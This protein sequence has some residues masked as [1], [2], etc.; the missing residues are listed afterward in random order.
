MEISHK[1][2]SLQSQMKI[3]M[4]AYKKVYFETLLGICKEIN[5]DMENQ[6]RNFWVGEETGHIGKGL[7]I[8][9][10]TKVGGSPFYLKM[11]MS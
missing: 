6:W 2:L 10:I 4:G 7:L 1:L 3:I 9:N 11:Y 8:N 5:Y